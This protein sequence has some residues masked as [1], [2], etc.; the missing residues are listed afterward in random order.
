MH[1]AQPNAV[2]Q[3]LTIITIVLLC[4]AGVTSLQAA[5]SAVIDPV[6]T[7]LQ[8]GTSEELEP[9]PQPTPNVAGPTQPTK[10]EPKP[11]T[12]APAAQAPAAKPAAKTAITVSYVNVR[13]GK[14]TST[15][16]I[17]NLEAGTAVTLT[18]DANST[19]QGISYQGKIGY[20]FKDYLQFQ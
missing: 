17:T 6:R 8:T 19:W 13:A 20:I 18:D 7:W 4:A 1:V 15:A 16:I 3:W 11:V 10:V 14:G 9:A 12:P 5:P 2:K